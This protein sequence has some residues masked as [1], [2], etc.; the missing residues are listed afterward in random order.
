MPIVHQTAAV[1]MRR[2]NVLMTIG[3]L[4][5]L[6]GVPATLLRMTAEHQIAVVEIGSD[7]LRS[8]AETVKGIEECYGM[9]QTFQEAKKNSEYQIEKLLM[10]VNQVV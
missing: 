9:I 6:I 1:L 8:P 5:N 2:F 4:N 3:N 7:P 10:A